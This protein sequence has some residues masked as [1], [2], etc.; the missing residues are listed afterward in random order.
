MRIIM[1]SNK[2]I[3]LNFVRVTSQGTFNNSPLSF[4][5]IAKDGTITEYGNNA[6]SR[7]LTENGLEILMWRINKITYVDGNYIEFVYDVNIK[8]WAINVF[9]SKI[10]HRKSII[11]LKE[12]VFLTQ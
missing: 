9:G 10:T 1:F 8:T 4:T 5:A 3:A 7:F 2:L 11:I 6:N 12:E